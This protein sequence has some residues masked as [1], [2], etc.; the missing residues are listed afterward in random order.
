MLF[1]DFL[2][3]AGIILVGMDLAGGGKGDERYAE[4]TGRSHVQ[5][6]AGHFH[7]VPGNFA[8]GVPTPFLSDWQE[9]SELTG[10]VS[11][12]RLIVNLNDRGAQLQGATVIHPKDIDELR[13]AISE[14]LKPFEP[15]G[16]DLLDK[17][18]AVQGNGM[19]QIL[20]HLANRC[21]RSWDGFP[22][23]EGSYRKRSDYLKTLFADRDMASL[24]GDFAFTVLPRITSETPIG[25]KEL[26]LAVDQV[27]NLIWRLEDAILEC[28]PDE[29][30]LIRFLT[31][32]F[33]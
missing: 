29:E 12:R 31:E 3:P 11:R 2:G 33:N 9:T 16:E 20:T 32:K 18:R 24:L 23:K 7:K 1:A 27:L 8:P 22:D 5:T 28:E 14:N 4:S 19:N 15:S 17:R 6:H 21:D 25:E 26:E 13:K 10:E 30:F